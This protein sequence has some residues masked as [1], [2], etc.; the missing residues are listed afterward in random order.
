MNQ[1]YDLSINQSLQN[2]SF[3]KKILIQGQLHASG[4][5]VTKNLSIKEI[6]SFHLST[7]S[8]IK[9]NEIIFEIKMVIIV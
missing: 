7:L 9:L 4:D 1:M 8:E 6:C 5:S 2:L 3:L